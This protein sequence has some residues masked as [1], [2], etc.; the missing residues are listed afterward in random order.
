MKRSDKDQPLIDDIRLLGRILGDVIREQEGVEAYELV[1]QVRKLSVAFR[2][3][4]DQDADRALKKLLKSLSGDQTV[5]V[6]R[7]FTYFSHLANLAEDRHHIRRRAVHE[8]AGD[9]QE[10]SIEVALSRLRWAGITPRTVAATLAGCYVS[11]VL[12]AHPTEVQRQTVLDAHKAIRRLLGQLGGEPLAPDERVEV[13]AE[14]KRVVLALWQTSEI[15][16]FKLTVKDEIEN[17][18]AYHPTTFFPALP[19]LY[20][21]LEDSIAREWGKKLELPNFFRIG[22]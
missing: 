19:K 7:A 8:R 11:P 20:A 18:V 5:S 13:E 14:L 17:G 9:T 6:I 12:T 16:P 2:R 4:A 15:R 1:E 22:Q 3:D 10:G 21:R